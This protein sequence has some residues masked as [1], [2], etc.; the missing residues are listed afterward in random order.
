MRFLIALL[1][2]RIHISAGL[3]NRCAAA[4]GSEPRWRR[5]WRASTMPDSRWCPWNTTSL[6]G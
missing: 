4:D 2:R 1:V 3:F 6:A 5:A